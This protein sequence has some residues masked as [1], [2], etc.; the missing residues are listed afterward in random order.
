MRACLSLQPQRIIIIISGL[1]PMPTLTFGTNPHAT[2]AVLVE[3]V[4]SVV[5]VDASDAVSF[6]KSIAPKATKH[7]PV[8]G[9]LTTSMLRLL[10]YQWLAMHFYRCTFYFAWYV[11]FTSV[12]VA[13]MPIG[14]SDPVLSFHKST[15]VFFCTLHT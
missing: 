3:Q 7:Q 5:G 4:S 1:T 13:V 12:L 9:L 2:T 8:D 11:A 15:R 6:L 14:M 10:V